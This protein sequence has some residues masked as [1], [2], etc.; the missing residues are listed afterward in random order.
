[1]GTAATILITCLIAAYLFLERILVTHP[2]LLP[3]YIL[4]SLISTILVMFAI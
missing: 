2:L 3:G 4:I 1:M